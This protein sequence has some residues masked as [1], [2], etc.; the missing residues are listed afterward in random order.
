MNITHENVLTDL[1]ADYIKLRADLKPVKELPPAET[2][3]PELWALLDDSE[4]K[5]RQ[6]AYEMRLLGEGAKKAE[7][8]DEDSKLY[9]KMEPPARIQFILDLQ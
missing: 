2:V 4:K 5:N 9:Q 8:R 3:K 6:D 1:V 7:K